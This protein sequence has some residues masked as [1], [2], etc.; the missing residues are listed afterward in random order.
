MLNNHS[1]SRKN[2]IIVGCAGVVTGI[3]AGFTVGFQ[4]LYLG[5]AI[6]AI[7]LVVY[8]FTNFEQAVLVLLILRTCLDP[9]SYQQAPAAFA[10]GVN[11]LTILYITVQL[12]TKQKVHT[13]SFFLFFACWIALQGLWVILP[14]FGWGLG[15]SQL[16]AGIREWM[17]MF[18]WLM[19]Y[20]LV[21]QLKEKIH[22]E[23]AVSALFFS[24]VVP[25]ITAIMQL[26]LPVSLLP[27]FLVR[28]SDGVYE[29][30]SRLISTLSHPSA[31]ATF[32]LLFI[33]LTLWKVEQ[34]QQ[35]KW[36]WLLLLGSLVFLMISTKAFTIM[37][38]FCV[39]ILALIAPKLNILKL[40]SAIIFLALVIGLFASTEFGQERFASLADTP[41]LNPNLDISRTILLSFGDGNSLNWRISQ[42]SFLIQAWQQSPI[43]GYGLGSSPYLTPFT[44]YFAHNDYVRFLSEEGIIGFGL[45]LLFIFTQFVRLRK[46]Y[47]LSPPGSP[48]G[49]LSLTM[50]AVLVAIIVGMTT[51]NIWSH[52]TLFFYWWLILATLGWDWQDLGLKN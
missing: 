44:G 41:L 34:S 7:G 5:L 14:A 33:A 37:F 50:M 46:F 29:A 43:L 11:I 10:I 36:L 9:F 27:A 23:K 1:P 19:I 24:L 2:G 17:R 32:L 21:M 45:F 51:E 39:F 16:A 3:V 40:I 48:Q 42:W 30:G 22:P 25:F 13:D 12:L 4:P 47:C 31:F 35:R 49:N 52:T 15:A 38:M 18:S 6:V 20:L 8:F 28:D 26:V